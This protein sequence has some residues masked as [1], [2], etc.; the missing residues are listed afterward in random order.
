M[1]KKY[2]F[3]AEI[4]GPEPVVKPT[5]LKKKKRRVKKQPKC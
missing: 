3:M 2:D 4:V 5:P 1:C